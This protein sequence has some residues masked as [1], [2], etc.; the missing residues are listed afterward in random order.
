MQLA[1]L[2]YMQPK[3]TWQ[4]KVKQMFLAWELEK[5]YSKDKIME[6]YLNNVYFANGYYGIDAACNGYFNCELK[7]LEDRKSTRLNSS[8]EI[9]SRMPSSA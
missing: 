3:Q 5:R 4:Y 6:F 7:D 2:I 9:P 8:H 1:K